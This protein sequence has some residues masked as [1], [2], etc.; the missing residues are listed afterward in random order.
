VDSI[1]IERTQPLAESGNPINRLVG[2][3]PGSGA[4]ALD[5]RPERAANRWS[6]LGAIPKPELLGNQ[7]EPDRIAATRAMW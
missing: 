4:Q 5:A 3:P 7:G 6:R 1:T 2:D